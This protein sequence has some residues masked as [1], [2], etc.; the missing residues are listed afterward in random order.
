[1]VHLLH[2]LYG[3]DAPADRRTDIHSHWLQ[4]L[5]TSWSGLNKRCLEL[6][7]TD[8]RV[9][10][11]RSRLWS[12]YQCSKAYSTIHMGWLYLVRAVS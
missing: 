2:R 12:C 9:L 6:D 10:W 1:M 3:V 11:T 5:P 4:P 8:P 7:W